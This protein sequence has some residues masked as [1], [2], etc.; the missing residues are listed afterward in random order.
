MSCI[1]TAVSSRG[2]SESVKGHNPDSSRTITYTDPVLLAI[3]GVVI[4]LLFIIIIVLVTVFR[5]KI[6]FL[7]KLIYNVRN[8]EIVIRTGQYYFKQIFLNVSLLNSFFF[9]SCLKIRLLSFTFCLIL[10][11][12]HLHFLIDS[13]CHFNILSFVILSHFNTVFYIVSN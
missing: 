8:D 12:S 3:I 5:R 11:L 6:K 10:A 9:T 13:Y 1:C 2:D 4:A 7:T